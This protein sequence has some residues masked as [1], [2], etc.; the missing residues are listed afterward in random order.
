MERMFTDQEIVSLLDDAILHNEIEAYFQ[1]QYDHSTGFLVGGE[2][3]ARWKHPTKGMV[4][5]GE[6]VPV[7]ERFGLIH[8]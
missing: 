7:L 3:L 8:I 4:S 5:P 2:G 1:P 6:F